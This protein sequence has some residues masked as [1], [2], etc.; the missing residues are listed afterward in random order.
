MMLSVLVRLKGGIVVP[1]TLPAKPLLRKRPAVCLGKW[2]CTTQ[3]IIG[4]GYS[5][6]DAYAA[7]LR[8]VVSSA[9]PFYDSTT[10][11]RLRWLEKK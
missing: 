3:G 10:L 9:G 2:E 4:T 1:R 5:E 7:W 6:R 11:Q 8:S